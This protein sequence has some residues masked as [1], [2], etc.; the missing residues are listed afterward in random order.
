[1]TAALQP[2]IPK[3]KQPTSIQNRNKRYLQVDAIGVGVAN[4]A[5]PFL[6][7]FPPVLVRMLCRLG[8]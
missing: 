7:V 5:G 8:Y 2:P 3:T 6:P 4:A 1:M